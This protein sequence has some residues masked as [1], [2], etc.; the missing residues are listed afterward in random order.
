MQTTDLIA[1]IAIAVSAFEA[2]GAPVFGQGLAAKYSASAERVLLGQAL[3][4]RRHAI[5][6]A[7]AL[8]EIAELQIEIA[9]VLAPDDRDRLVFG[10]ALR[11]VAG[12]A[13]RRLVLDRIRPSGGR[14]GEERGRDSDY[15]TLRE[16]PRALTSRAFARRVVARSNEKAAALRTCD[17]GA[18]AVRSA[19][20]SLDREGDDGVAALG[21][22]LGV[23]ARADDDVLLAADHVGGRRR[24]D[25]GAGLEL[26]QA[27]CRWP[28]CRP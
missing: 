11:A 14:A 12:V 16:I 10:H 19:K 27:P 13:E 4:D 2:V 3:G 18:A 28:S 15:A 26:P 9:R 24:I 21:V 7:R 22:D 25:A 1:V 8:L 6:L 20:R 23:A 5:V 17:P